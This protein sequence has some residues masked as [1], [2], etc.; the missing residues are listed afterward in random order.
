MSPEH[1]I[2]FAVPVFF[3]IGVAESRGDDAA[4]IFFVGLFVEFVLGALALLK[5]VSLYACK[6]AWERS[7]TWL[8]VLMILAGMWVFSSGPVGILVA[9][10][11]IVGGIQALERSPA[12]ARE[13]NS[14]SPPAP[15]A[16]GSA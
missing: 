13:E 16:S 15:A 4:A 10:L 5:L 1:A 14:E 11:T 6:R 3:G 9:G 2:A 12:P 7:R 8:I